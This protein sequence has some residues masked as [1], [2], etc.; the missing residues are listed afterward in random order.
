MGD[1]GLH[2]GNEA[3][4]FYTFRETIFRRI[5]YCSEKERNGPMRPNLRSIPLVT[6]FLLTPV[7]IFAQDS[8]ATLSVRGDIQKPTQWSVEALKAQFG[9]QI[10][11]VKFSAG[12][13]QP[14]RV[15]TGIPLLAVI[16]A[17]APKTEQATRHHDLAF[18][19]IVEASDSYHVFFSLAELM[20]QYSHAQVWLIWN[21]DGK[22]LSGKEAP[23]RLVVPTDQARDRHVFGVTRIT[24]AAFSSQ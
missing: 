8:A 19:A 12:K 5:N 24:V 4:A 18:P 2:N 9:G 6:V 20:P 23:L 10:Q 11:D 15:G 16:Q 22:P 17:A 13:D 21:V 1:T 7:Y 3:N 14:L